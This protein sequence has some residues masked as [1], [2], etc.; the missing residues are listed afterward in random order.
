[1]LND[2]VTSIEHELAQEWVQN[3]P[4][5]DDEGLNVPLNQYSLKGTMSCYKQLIS[6]ELFIEMYHRWIKGEN[7]E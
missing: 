1:M 7:N 2:N 3:K 5:I 4:Y 6:K